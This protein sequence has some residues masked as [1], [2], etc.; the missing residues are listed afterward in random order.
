MLS[1]NIH[2]RRDAVETQNGI[3]TFELLKNV[4]NRVVAMR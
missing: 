1:T 4:V 3:E 2:P